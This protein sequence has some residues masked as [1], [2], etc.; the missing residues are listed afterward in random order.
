MRRQQSS[1]LFCEDKM[2]EYEFAGFISACLQRKLLTCQRL[3]CV[4]VRVRGC[5]QC[6][7]S[8]RD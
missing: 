6:Q 1:A 5:Y 2:S 3:K 7:C 8:R 4:E